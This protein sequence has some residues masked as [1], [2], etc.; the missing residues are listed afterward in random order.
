[1]FEVIVLK[2]FKIGAKLYEKTKDHVKDERSSRSL[3][4]IV[5]NT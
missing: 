3:P 5:Y 1:M 2:G 4:E